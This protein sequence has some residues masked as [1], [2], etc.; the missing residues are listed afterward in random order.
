VR[1]AVDAWNAAL[2]VVAVRDDDARGQ[3]CAA[4]ITASAFYIVPGCRPNQWAASLADPDTAPGSDQIAIPDSVVAPKHE[5]YGFVSSPPVAEFGDWRSFVHATPKQSVVRLET[6]LAPGASTGRSTRIEVVGKPRAI[7][8]DGQRKDVVHGVWSTGAGIQWRSELCVASV[9]RQTGC[10]PPVRGGQRQRGGLV[11]G[12]TARSEA[13]ASAPPSVWRLEVRRPAGPRWSALALDVEPQH[14]LPPAYRRYARAI[15]LKE[16]AG[17][18]S[19]SKRWQEG[20]WRIERPLSLTPTL[21]LHCATTTAARRAPRECILAWTPQSPPAQ[22]EPRLPVIAV[23]RDRGVE[24]PLS[25]PTGV[26]TITPY[27]AALG[28]APLIGLDRRDFLGLGPQLATNHRAAARILQSP[29]TATQPDGVK[30]AVPV[31]LRIPLTIDPR[32]QCLARRRLDRFLATADDMQ[33]PLKH[34]NDRRAAIVLLDTGPG[35]DMGAIRAAASS[36][37]PDPLRPLN[38]WDH[39][40]IDAT[41]PRACPTSPLAWS[42][43]DKFIMPGSTFKVVVALAALQES[44]REPAMGLEPLLLGITNPMTIERELR[45]DVRSN[46]PNVGGRTKFDT[47]FGERSIANFKSSP[48]SR[49]FQPP[50]ATGCPP[51]V[52]TTPTTPQL[53]LC[54]AISKSLNGWFAQ[55]A[56][57]L[58]RT[59]VVAAPAGRPVDNLKIVAMARRLFGDTTFSLTPIA[60]FQPARGAKMFATPI[61]LGVVGST[62]PTEPAFAIN[63]EH[64]LALNGIGQDVQ[65]SPLAMATVFA[66]LAARSI[67]RPR[68]T[69]AA[70]EGTTVGGIPLLDGVPADRQEAV[71]RP[72]LDGLAGVVRTGTAAETFR[73]HAT[74]RSRLFAKTGTADPE[75]DP[76]S[77]NTVW[78]AGWLDPAIGGR[79]APRRLAFACMITHAD[80]TGGGV[81]APLMRDLLA[82]VEGDVP[83]SPEG[84]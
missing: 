60:E 18:A 76:N 10:Q 3:A 58:D 54:E 63:R 23:V 68:L 69:A 38:L 29:I 83:C 84:R 48:A 75:D 37:Q 57:R 31:A 42:Q 39:R 35:P 65:A 77:P 32:L 8:I 80:G 45:I 67:V 1:S 72:L 61:S 52:G 40:A 50:Q 17:L 7:W 22:S 36:R 25:E 43:T 66:S 11:A 73:N 13:L 24:R 28:L 6:Q 78:F 79:S 47:R 26:G 55:M 46:D 30:V 4:S 20:R 2:A 74:L 21:A 44:V 5:V 27:A 9:D 62:L 12:V 70:L 33:L 59:A 56:L 53:G 82:D 14:H 15:W 81:C 51:S 49:A 64:V 16:A 19:A 71:L 41:N 34:R